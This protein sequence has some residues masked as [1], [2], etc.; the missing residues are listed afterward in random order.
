MKLRNQ[1]TRHRADAR[2]VQRAYSLCEGFDN[3]TDYI[4]LGRLSDF[5]VFHLQYQ[6]ELIVSGRAHCGEMTV[7]HDGVS[8][9]I[10]AHEYDHN[11]TEISGLTWDADISGD[12]VRLVLT[13]AGVGENTRLHYKVNRSAVGPSEHTVRYSTTSELTIHL[14]SI[15]GDDETGDGSSG[16]PFQSLS[17]L[18]RLPYEIRHQIKVT[19]KAGTYTGWPVN[20]KHRYV[21][22]GRIILDASGETFPVIAGPFTL[23]AATQIGPPSALGCSFATDIEVAGAGWASDEHYGK[24]MRFLSGNWAG[25]VLP[26]YK[27]TSDAIRT[28][29]DPRG[30]AAGDTFEI[31]DCPVTISTSD[32]V[33]IEGDGCFNEPLYGVSDI[34]PW[35]PHFIAG[36]VKFV[37]DVGDRSFTFKDIVGY[38]SFCTFVDS[39]KWVFFEL[40]NSSI[41]YQVPPATVFD[42]P[43]LAD[44]YAC[45]VNII[46]SNGALPTED[47]SNIMLHNSQLGGFTNHQRVDL[48]SSFRGGVSWCM[49][50][51]F[52]SE[53]SNGIQHIDTAY[54]EQVGYSTNAIDANGRTRIYSAYINGCARALHSRGR[55]FAWWFKGENIANDY[56]VEVD[57][58]GLVVNRGG[59][60]V[61]IIGAV[62]AIEFPFSGTNHATWPALGAAHTDNA[63][64]YVITK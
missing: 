14:D 8:A 29:G 22:N 61:D 25:Y 26:V 59:A 20:M 53:Y 34:S 35:G 24:F 9:W 45:A 57:E 50:G 62:G 31:V 44:W 18:E 19:P 47:G 16:N 15:N 32:H 7:M 6:L 30:Y 10:A 51:G 37:S 55:T 21:E 63:G 3:D 23:S 17:F 60:D 11:G 43:S 42:N 41:N 64:S 54:F 39:E 48:R 33:T 56:A 40:Y 2:Y 12:S 1:L 13:K 28:Y 49:I 27:N 58:A 52:T 46:P 5:S 4:V 36:G 38:L